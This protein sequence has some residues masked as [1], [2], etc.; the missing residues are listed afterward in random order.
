M[1]K[2]KN[3]LLL[4]LSPVSINGEENT[5]F[6]LD[7]GNVYQVRGFMT[8]EAPAKSVIE[9]L[10]RDGGKRLDKIVLISSQTTRGKIIDYKKNKDPSEQESG[11]IKDKIVSLGKDLEQITHLEY[12]E[13]VVNAF[14]VNIDEGYREKPISYNIVPIPD[15]A[16]P[17][18]VA[19]A[20]VK[21]AD[22]V[23]MQGNDVDLY[24]DYN[25]GPRN[26]AFMILSI[27]NLMKIREV[28]T[29]EIMSMNFDNPGKNGIPIRRMA[30]IFECVDLV[31]GINE[32]VNYG[33]VKVLKSYFK[34][35]KDERIHE[36][37]S[38][39]EEFSNYLQLCRTRDVLNY[40]QNLKE[41]L[42]EYLDNTQTNPGT[43]TRD[44]LFSYVVKDILAGY[45]DLLDG[46]MPEVIK[47]CVEKDFIQQALTFYTDRM[48]IYFW[49]SGIFHPSK[50]EEED[51]TSFLALGKQS[52]DDDLAEIYG[53]YYK[54]YNEDYCWMT[55]YITSSGKKGYPQ[56]KLSWKYGGKVSMEDIPKEEFAM[57]QQGGLREAEEQA[58]KLMGYKRVGRV[59]SVVCNLELKKILI[60]YHLIREQRNS[61]NHASDDQTGRGNGLGY[62]ETCR[63]LY[64][65]ADRIQ[66]VLKQRGK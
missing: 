43:D 32:Y 4:C 23:M 25:G 61:T 33:R 65:A 11:S 55:K 19:R 6:Y 3:V 48:P 64:Q 13:E 49:D 17:N 38:A 9:R 50:V 54:H 7:E 44:V 52:K 28:N 10:H 8:N 59:N 18:E 20:A 15:K 58:G 45:R 60:E 42:Q 63:L 34:D 22:Y 51:Y 26:V 36:I 16:E 37:L 39:M 1:Q 12:Y 57:F 40:K 29:K 27:S 47:W 2:K 31:A 35:S 53:T 66:K 21:A 24:I 30:S 14:A 5:Y 56:G 62:K 46:D 41:K